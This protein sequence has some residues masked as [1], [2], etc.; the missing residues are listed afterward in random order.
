MVINSKLAIRHRSQC[1]VSF[2]HSLGAFPTLFQLL[3][4]LQ[5]QPLTLSTFLKKPLKNHAWVSS[6]DILTTK[7]LLFLI[8]FFPI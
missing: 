7:T 3:L 2:S 6:M 8:E 5:L 4:E 1:L